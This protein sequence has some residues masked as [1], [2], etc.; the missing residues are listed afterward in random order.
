M[1]VISRDFDNLLGNMATSLMKKFDECYE[2]PEKMNV[3]LFFG[4]VLDP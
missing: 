2:D 3:V 4:I 1:N